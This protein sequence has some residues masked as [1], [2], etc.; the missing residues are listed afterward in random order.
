MY[1]H[2]CFS[3]P[4]YVRPE[5]VSKHTDSNLQCASRLVCVGC[6]WQSARA[7]AE[8]TEFACAVCVSSCAS[9]TCVHL[10]VSGPPHVCVWP[11]AERTW[12]EGWRA[13]LAFHGPC[14][15]GPSERH[16]F[17]K[18]SVRPHRCLVVVR[19]SRVGAIAC[20]SGHL[21]CVYAY[22]L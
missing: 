1:H 11:W 3:T 22:I 16:W 7:S 15:C 13:T 19:S 6:V 10:S 9:G 14:V 17:C 2:R 20:R 12:A 18:L 21:V 5:E 4:S 8:P